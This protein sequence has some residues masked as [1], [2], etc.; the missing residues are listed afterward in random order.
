MLAAVFA[1]VLM[2]QQA[3]AGQIV[4]NTPAP[5]EPAAPVVAAPPIPDWARSDPYGYERSECSPLIRQANETM[6]ACQSRVR[7]ALAANLGENM[8][9]DLT[10]IAA[11]D[12][13]R[14]EAS[15]GRYDMECSTRARS[16]LPSGPVLQEDRACANRPRGQTRGGIAWERVCETTPN[17][18][19][20]GLKWTFGGRD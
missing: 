15:D 20:D 3:A 19:S 10:P 16:E 8:P 4:W 17:S 9:R 12:Q 11:T 2:M 7:I 1:S 18:Q 6:E 14:Q 5:V 13:C